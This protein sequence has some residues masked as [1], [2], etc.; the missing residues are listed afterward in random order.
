MTLTTQLINRINN[1]K[2]KIIYLA[3]NPMSYAKSS[4]LA[5]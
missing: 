2:K 4:N 5:T 3:T 1:A